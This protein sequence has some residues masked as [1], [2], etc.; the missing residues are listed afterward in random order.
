M[1][2]KNEV[3]Q[4]SPVPIT[5]IQDHAATSSQQPT[6]QQTCEG[7]QV[8]QAGPDQN[9]QWSH[10]LNTVVVIVSHYVLLGNNS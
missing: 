8:S 3:S 4:L 5:T 1:W 2:R 7:A 10:K 6:C 9:N